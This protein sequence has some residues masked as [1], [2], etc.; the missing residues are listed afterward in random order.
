MLSTVDKT[1][2]KNTNL[3]YRQYQKLLSKIQELM[4]DSPF[5]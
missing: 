3:F 4:Q 5:L 1:G 2:L